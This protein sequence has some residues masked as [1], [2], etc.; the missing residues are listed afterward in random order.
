MANEEISGGLDTIDV[1]RLF[2]ELRLTLK[3][4][5]KDTAHFLQ[6]IVELLAEHFGSEVCSLYHLSDDGTGLFLRATKGLRAEAVG[7]TVLRVGEGLVGTVAESR[8]PLA[9]ESAQEDPR[10][11]FRPETGEE[12][13]HSFLGVPLI[14][15]QTLLG[16]LVLQHLDSRRFSPEEVEDLETVAQFLS[17]MLRQLSPRQAASDEKTASLRLTAVPISA[18]LAIG[19]AVLHMKDTVIQRWRA[20]RSEARDGAAYSTRWKRFKSPSSSSR[21]SPRKPS[22]RNCASCWRPT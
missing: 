5:E 22:S 4:G 11:T 8:K 2:R 12:I 7:R 9:L 20:R 1:R 13:Y 16:V 21:H 18:G 17:E 10:F 14:R 3:G 6:A 15:A 19:T